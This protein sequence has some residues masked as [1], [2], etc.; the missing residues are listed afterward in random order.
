MTAEF[1]SDV[2][3][4]DKLL[5]NTSDVV[6]YDDCRAILVD[7]V[8]DLA[9]SAECRAVCL[10]TPLLSCASR[11]STAIL[12]GSIADGQLRTSVTPLVAR[13]IKNACL[14]GESVQQALIDAKA[15]EWLMAFLAQD[16]APTEIVAQALSNMLAGNA[17]AIQQVLPQLL[18]NALLM[19]KLLLDATPSATEAA[20][21]LLL[22]CVCVVPDS[23]IRTPS[24][25][26]VIRLCLL[27]FRANSATTDSQTLV[28]EIFERWAHAHQLA[29]VHQHLWPEDTSDVSLDD[30]YSSFLQLVSCHVDDDA[31]AVLP[32]DLLRLL[33]VQFKASCQLWQQALSGAMMPSSVAEWHTDAIRLLLN[34]FTLQTQERCS[35]PTI[36]TVLVANGLLDGA[37]GLLQAV[38]AAQPRVVR[39]GA[40]DT[41]EADGPS[42]FTF[43]R[44]L[45]MLLSNLA[46][47]NRH[48]QDLI[49][50]R[51]CLTLILNLCNYDDNHAFIREY[52]TLALRNVMEGNAENQRI[53]EALRPQSIADDSQSMLAEQGVRASIDEETGKL[54]LHQSGH[55]GS[56]GG[57]VT[58]ADGEPSLVSDIWQLVKHD[59]LLVLAVAVTAIAGAL[60]NIWLPRITGQLVTAISKSV[61]RNVA[62]TGASPTSPTPQPRMSDLLQYAWG[63]IKT[64]IANSPELG[65][66][67]ARLLGLF[68]I[69][70]VLTFA[71]VSMITLL[72]ESIAL[73][74]RHRLFEALV[75]QDIAFFDER[76]S[77]ELV[78][79]IS[80]DVQEFKHTFKQS[81]TQ[82]L[83]CVTEVVGSVS[84]LAYLS[85]SL[86]CT[87]ALTMPILYAMGN[88]YG[89]Y[90]RK[91]SAANKRVDG[92]A[93]GV[94]GEALSNIR[95]VK[96]Y[97]AED[98]E[99]AMY[100][101]AAAKASRT[102][103]KLGVHIGLFQALTSTSIGSMILVVLYYGG[104]LVAQGKMEAGDLMTYLMST[105]ATQ[106][107]TVGVL[108]GQLIKTA[109]ASQRVF[110]YIHLQPTI[111]TKGGR[112]PESIVGKIEFHQVRFTY[113]TRPD[114]IV[115]DDFNLTL[116]VGKV[117]AL[118]GPSGSGK[119]TI[120]T[121]IERFYDV[122]RGS[123][124]IDGHDV[125]D[126]DPRHVGL[127][128]IRNHIGYVPQQPALFSSSIF[129]NIRY[130][131][132]DATREEVEQAAKLANAHDFIQ[133][134][135]A[136]Y[137]T[138]VGER[139][140]AL[141][142]GQRQRI[143]IAATILKDPSILIL[144]EATS[145][146]DNQS[147]K[148]V[149]EALDRL[150]A[151]RTVLVIAHR[152]STIANADLIV[153]MSQ[154]KQQHT[155][156]KG[157][158]R[159]VEMGTHEELL[160]KRG[161]Y[162]DLYEAGGRAGVE[163][164]G[165]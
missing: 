80:A 91:L 118:C 21:R 109:A 134:F 66:P 143:A 110:E 87:L 29:S 1:A 60:A 89:S 159:I 68:A 111:P 148:L 101:A 145:A 152:L 162:F 32:D 95:T 94:A 90:L 123:V 10:Q 41:H 153:V 6:S 63:T 96:A 129:E 121:L 15:H 11:L 150:M 126:L 93:G 73:R 2:A 82:G 119:S 105:Q 78:G 51:S 22:N 40:P 84:H 120:A 142:G 28:Y 62:A 38:C 56:A 26:N 30:A 127:L 34:I 161:V 67:A 12:D 117:V 55:K 157:K 75:Q 128:W 35:L 149:Q 164:S 156:G 154:A 98:R 133:T 88:V 48:V 49:R 70:G 20:L 158:G 141:S 125:R 139:G 31:K 64:T 52:A 37:L 155:A 151:G 97:A 72:G 137:D 124:T 122:D 14:Q 59:W 23:L 76:K 8:G 74:L 114:Q 99:V 103:I 77:G 58:P 36:N 135:P 131:K 5:L 147:E 57:V 85:P 65:R 132:P 45:L 112:V 107:T 69:K 3:D 115:L 106:R 130:G 18:D 61:I 160:R 50:E 108:V 165:L 138:V 19:S 39:R 146:L 102:N 140:L 86:T 24:G 33:A 53:I 116:P 54:R 9:N 136:G 71:H 43:R 100:D 7:V 83:K 163:H 46:Y 79:R 44:D 92:E 16:D 27:A 4:L 47:H 113:P 104:S 144:D 25:Y 17:S 42:V 13:A 81:L